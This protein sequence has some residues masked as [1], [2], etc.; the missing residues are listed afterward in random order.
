MMPLR[1]KTS[2]R[3]LSLV[4]MMISLAIGSVLTI[5]VVGLF[6]ANSETY[7]TLQGQTRLQE[8]AGFAL[9][10]ISRDLQR[11]G[12]RGCFSS[13]ASTYFT[14][15][16]ASGIPYESNMRVGIELFN[17][18]GDG[19]WVPST[20]S[21]NGSVTSAA[22]QDSDLLTVRYLDDDEAYL[23]V[24]LATS[25]EPIAVTITDEG[26]ETLQAGDIALLHDCEKA[27]LFKVTAL[28][29]AGGTTT[30]QHAVGVGASDN[31]TLALAETGTFSTDAAVSG[32]ITRTYF[33]GLG[34][35]TNNDGNRPLSLWRR[36]NDSAAVELVEGVEDFQVQLAIDTDGDNIPNQYAN[37]SSSVN[38]SQ[39]MAVVITLTTN[40]VDAIGGTTAPTW[41]CKANEDQALTAQDC[42]SNSSVD[43]LL[44]RTFSRT[45]QI[46]N[47]T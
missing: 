14:M 16:S 1:S 10:T 11:A 6:T 12:Y 9:E 13:G 35:G 5:G 15:S 46:R 40:S 33:V 27:T 41:G 38:F 4:E 23:T 28:A 2:N 19:S 29:E 8:S 20:A 30:L 47:Q 31:A 7:N 39:V 25:I 22:F 42:Y 32:I 3:G 17:A 26:L 18:V 44:R 24:P 37:A 43:G 21:I 45:I 36:E 34:A